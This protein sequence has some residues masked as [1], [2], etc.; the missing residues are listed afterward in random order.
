MGI[1]NKKTILQIPY[2]TDEGEK[3]CKCENDLILS[4]F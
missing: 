4:P 3:T 1:A 2:Q